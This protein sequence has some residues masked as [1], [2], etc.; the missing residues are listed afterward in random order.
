VGH[1]S[2]ETRGVIS[3]LVGDEKWNFSSV[4]LQPPVKPISR[5][6][7]VTALHRDKRKALRSLTSYQALL[8]HFLSGLIWCVF[9]LRKPSRECSKPS[10]P[11]GSLRNFCGT[12][13][14]TGPFAMVV[15][16]STV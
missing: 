1:G 2:E 8:R 14:P 6:T 9:L 15:P 10:S 7:N 13:S 16:P 12:K 4:N 11:F 5:Q 3:Y